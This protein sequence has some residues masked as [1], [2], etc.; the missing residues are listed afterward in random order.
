MTCRHL[1]NVLG[2]SRGNDL[3]TAGATFWAQVEDP[4]GGFDDIQVVFDRND[5]VAFFDQPVEHDEQFADV[6]EVQPGG[7]FVEY[8][9][10]F[11]GCT[12]LQLGGG[13]TRWASPP[14]GLWRAEAHRASPTST[15]D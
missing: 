11:T 8:V 1:G 9:D 14:T 5:G 2:G 4:V 6:F 10:R 7:G 15:S 13:L 3:A 12:A